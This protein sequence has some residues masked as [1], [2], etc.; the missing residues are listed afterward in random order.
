VTV[1]VRQ[2]LLSPATIA[3]YLFLVV[4]LAVGW[5]R[6]SLLSPL[7]LPGYLIYVVGT[8]IGNLFAPRLAFWVYWIPF[9]VGCYGVAVVVGLGYELLC[10]RVLT[11]GR[12]DA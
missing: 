10:D 11:D 6:T 8:A 4:P 9:L 2:V 1:S 3:T 7:A 12:R 5:F